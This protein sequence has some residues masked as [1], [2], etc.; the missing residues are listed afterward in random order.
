VRS[1]KAVAVCFQQNHGSALLTTGR[2]RDNF[3]AE[4]MVQD[5]HKQRSGRPWTSASPVSAAV[6]MQQFTR[7]Q[8]K[9]NK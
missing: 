1:P 6:V 3:E 5:V 8:Q 9:I 4:G 2:I 7:A